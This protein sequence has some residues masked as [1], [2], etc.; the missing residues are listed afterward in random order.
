M[1]ETVFWDTAA[2]VALG[3]QDDSLHAAAIA[4][5]QRLGRERA[6]ILTTDAVLTEVANT[7]SKTAWRPMARR[8]IEAIEQSSQIGVAQVIHVD[9]A[10]WQ[11]GWELFLKRPDKDWSLTDCT[12]CVVMQERK[13]TRAFTS[14]RH[15]EQAGF[16]CLIRK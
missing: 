2:F 6:F 7:F 8:A 1:P 12:S 14:D 4:V 10:L 11:R 3:N 16:I 9:G 13:L 5:S 15:F